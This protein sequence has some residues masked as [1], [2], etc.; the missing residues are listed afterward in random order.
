MDTISGFWKNF[1]CFRFRFS[2]RMTEYQFLFAMM[3]EMF[4]IWTVLAWIFW[5]FALI[6]YLAMVSSRHGHEGHLFCKFHP[7][8]SPFICLLSRRRPGG[9]NNPKLLS[10]LILDTQG[11]IILVHNRQQRNIL[12]S[13]TEI[14]GSSSPD[15]LHSVVCRIVRPWTDLVTSTGGAALYSVHVLS[16]LPWDLNVMYWWLGNL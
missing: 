6:A 10:S 9:D 12:P 5:I 14:T 11:D 2:K 7:F 13:D 15:M 1:I 3:F 8:G 4:D 16:T